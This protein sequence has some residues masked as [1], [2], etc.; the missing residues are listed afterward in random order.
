MG[1]LLPSPIMTIQFFLPLSLEN[2]R[3]TKGSRIGDR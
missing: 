3:W 1:F 2:I